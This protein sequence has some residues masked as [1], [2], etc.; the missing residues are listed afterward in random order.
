M[1]K[2]EPLLWLN[3]ARGIYI[4]RDFVQSIYRKNVPDVSDEDWAILNTGPEHELY[5]DAWDAVLSDAVVH[6]ETGDY[7]LYQDGDL[8][9]VPVGMV[10]NEETDFFEWPNDDDAASK[11][12]EDQDD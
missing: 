11:G 9:L 8:W 7:R 12:E 3:D 6:D 10:W 2:P 4:P 1:N 5:W